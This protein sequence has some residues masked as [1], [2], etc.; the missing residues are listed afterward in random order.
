MAPSAPPSFFLGAAADAAELGRAAADVA[1]LGRAFTAEPGRC[2]F[3]EPLGLPL[4][5]PLG[6]DDAADVLAT[7]D[8]LEA[9]A[10]AATGGIRVSEARGPP[11]KKASRDCGPCGAGAMSGGSHAL[12]L[13]LAQLWVVNSC[14]CV[15]SMY[16][17]PR[18]LH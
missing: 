14:C 18:P 6:E 12:R 11:R 5:L 7:A 1:E 10:L 17:A 8:A 16:E 15:A 2:G 13:D 4:G 3:G 9:G